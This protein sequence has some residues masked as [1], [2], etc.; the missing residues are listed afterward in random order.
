M[1]IGQS[2]GICSALTLSEFELSPFQSLSSL[3]VERKKMEV[4]CYTEE[5]SDCRVLWELHQE[6]KSTETIQSD[7]PWSLNMHYG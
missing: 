5:I 2:N 6:A 3:L 7:C 4:Q 1:S